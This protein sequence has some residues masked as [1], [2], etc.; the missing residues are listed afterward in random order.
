MA[1]KKIL[2]TGGCGYIGGHTIVDLIENGFDVI[3]VDDLSKGSLRMLHGVEKIVGKTVKN[4]KVNLCDLEDTEA[5]FI[6]NPDIV[7]VVHFAAYKSVPESVREPLKYFRNNINSLVNVLQCAKEYGVQNFVFSSS[8]SVYGNA[9]ELPVNEEA[10]LKEPESPYARTKQMGEAI[11]ADFCV[12]NKKFNV[13][14]LRYFNPVGAHMSA[15]IGELQEVPENLVPVITQTAIGK[16]KDMQVYGSDY[17]TRDGSCVRDYIH[18]MDIA[19]A[20]TKALQYMLDGKNTEHCEVFN[21]GTGQGVTVLEL[22]AAF[23]KV[24]GQ[25]LNYKIGARRPGD[26]VAVYANN[27]K[28]AT[29]LGWETKYDLDQMMDTAW[30]WELYLKREAEKIQ[31]N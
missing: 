30:R 23:E 13:V 7:G 4:Y 3:C 18:V 10:K 19:N 29:K 12:P 9:D 14:L 20:H 8:C 27:N 22:I 17:P 1:K 26:V 31:L 24:S 6:E 25:K 16:R 2:V 11:C 28:A 21:L 15:T 5:I